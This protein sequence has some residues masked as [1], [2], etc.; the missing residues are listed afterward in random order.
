M[1]NLAKILIV[2][3][4]C[5]LQVENLIIIIKIVQTW[6]ND[7]HMNFMPNNNKKDYLKAKGSL[8]NDNYELN[9]ETKYFENLNMDSD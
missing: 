2:L 5:Q 8:V 9:E 3:Q 6:P 7:A 1:F 4:Q